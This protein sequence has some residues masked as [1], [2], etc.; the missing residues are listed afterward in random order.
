L[1]ID[2][3]YR[4]DSFPLYRRDKSLDMLYTKPLAPMIVDKHPEEVIEEYVE[5]SAET[6][7]EPVRFSANASGEVTAETSAYLKMPLIDLTSELN[8]WELGLPRNMRNLA[9]R[10][11][12]FYNQWATDY[13]SAPYRDIF[14]SASETKYTSRHDGRHNL[15]VPSELL[16]NGVADDTYRSVYLH[17]YKGRSSR[18]RLIKRADAPL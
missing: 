7:L 14:T 5:S 3:N 1:V 10:F 11:R 18:L 15:M 12:K 4:D 6:A 9:V 8:T 13:N 17:D 2:E 16:F